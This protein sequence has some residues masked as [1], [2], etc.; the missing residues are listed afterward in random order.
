MA[1]SGAGGWGGEPRALICR[2]CG[3]CRIL[4]AFS[5]QLGRREQEYYFTPSGIRCYPR[6]TSHRKAF[7]GPQLAQ[8]LS[9]TC[10]GFIL[11]SKARC[12]TEAG[13]RE[14]ATEHLSRV[15][16]MEGWQDQIT[17]EVV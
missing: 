1:H 14:L 17:A 3:V 6:L 4:L 7:L 5:M 2:V 8:P 10:A 12:P 9:C 11:L 13:G 16:V 15:T